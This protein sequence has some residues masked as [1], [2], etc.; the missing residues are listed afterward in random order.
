M[1]EVE[2]GL[3]EPTELEPEQGSLELAGPGDRWTNADWEKSAAAVLRKARRLGE[4]DPDSRVWEKLGRTTLDGIAVL[5]LGTAAVLEE[6]ETSGRPTRSG[7]WDIRV[8]LNGPDVKLANEAALVDLNGGATSLWLELGAGLTPEDLDATLADVLLDLAPVV[9]DAPADPLAAAEALVAVLDDRGVTPADG[10]NLGADPIGA[11]VRGVVSTGST[12]E[13][14]ATAEGTLVAV[15]ELA[16]AAGTLGVV[17][18]ATAVH[19]LGASDAQELGYSLAVG[20][21]YLRTLT[22][23]GIPLDEALGLIEF[24]Y[25]ATDE[26]FPTI[27]K[28]RA[29]RRLWARVVELSEGSVS[30][31]RQHAVTSRPMMSKY[32]PWVNMLRTTVAAFGAGVGGADSV[33]VL[34]FDS[35]LGRPDAFGRR[36]ARNTSSLLIAESHVA[37]VADPAGGA[38]AVEKLTDDLA[39]AGWAELGRIEEAGGIEAA[40]ADGSMRARIDETVARREEEVARRRRPLTGVTEFPH[41]AEVLPER[42]PDETVGRVRRYGA[43]FEALR[44]DPATTPVFLATMGSVAAHTARATFASNLLAAGGIAV[45]V[46]GPTATADE[47]V[48]AYDGQPV[49]CLAGSDPTYAELAPAAI[50]AL[51]DAGARWVILA[52]KPDDLDVDD[53]CAMGVDALAFLNRTREHLA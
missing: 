27:A 19:D 48:A 4:D 39:R 12:T 33:T 51:R 15:A 38:Y 29:A 18:D 31:Q 1:T 16:R 24:R 14:E 20:A 46:A 53:S 25:A 9:L 21:A 22:E 30:A 37:H 44:D 28:L 2:G 32:D 41:L 40:L 45:D 11:R 50:T 5:P 26:Q 47:L 35:V 17:V 23:A 42:E 8:H 6:V 52:G 49:V 43:S 7:D 36:I 10:T 13:N 34:P 3:A